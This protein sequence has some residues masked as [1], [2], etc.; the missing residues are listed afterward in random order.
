MADQTQFRQFRQE[1]LS[2]AGFHTGAHLVI[3]EA[4]LN[5]LSVHS[6]ELIH[7]RVFDETLDGSLHKIVLALL[8]ENVDASIASQLNDVNDFLFEDVLLP[9]ERA[10]TF[11]GIMAPTTADERTAARA[12][13]DERY[14]EYFSFFE[15]LLPWTD[16]TFVTFLLAFSF[17]RFAFSSSRL[18]EMHDVSSLN[19]ARLREIDGPRV[20]L[21]AAAAAFLED[22]ELAS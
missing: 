17:A 9:H 11:L 15:R 19:V 16:S 7:G 14:G 2:L 6:H 8:R 3:D 10:A 12:A 1:I 4:H 20:R 18:A 13:L 22:G 21:E 5:N